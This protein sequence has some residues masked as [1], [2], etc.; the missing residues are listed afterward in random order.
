[1]G[2]KLSYLASPERHAVSQILWGQQA[3]RRK[4]G[5]LERRLSS[6]EAIQAEQEQDLLDTVAGTDID[7]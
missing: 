5:E 7:P 6:L 1:L 3:D 2:F 4:I